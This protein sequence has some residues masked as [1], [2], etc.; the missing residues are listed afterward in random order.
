RPREGDLVHPGVHVAAAYSWRLLVIGVAAYEVFTILAR[1]QLVAVAL[2]LALV[3]TSLLRPVADLLARG[4][5]RAPAVVLSVVGSAVLLLGLLALVGT[6][7]AGEVN[8]LTAEFHGG[9]GQ[10]ERWLQRPP[11]RI[12]PGTLSGLDDK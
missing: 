9:I 10:I 1:F 2:F 3:G 8:Q 6:A 12:R 5:P 7:V 11:F 4:M